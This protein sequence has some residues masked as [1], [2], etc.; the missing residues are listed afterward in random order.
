[1]AKREPV[2]MYFSEEEKEQI[3]QE[4]AAEDKSVSTYCRDIVQEH[5][6]QRTAEDLDAEERLERVLAEGTDHMAT[7]ADDIREQNG[8]VIHLLRE[9]ESQLDAV[10]VDDL[11]DGA[12]HG[13]GGADTDTEDDLF[14]RLRGDES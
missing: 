9:I 6:F 5:R 2:T 1:M 11:A 8:L 7:I 10:D 14:E 12:D 4:A 13:G 3:K